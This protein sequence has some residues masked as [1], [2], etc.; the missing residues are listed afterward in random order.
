MLLV[1]ADW[2]PETKEDCE[3]NLGLTKYL[4]AVGAMSPGRVQDPEGAKQITL[5]YTSPAGAI[6]AIINRR[7]FIT[8]YT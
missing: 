2:F 3:H 7:F 1:E 5:S 6:A 4:E 8:C